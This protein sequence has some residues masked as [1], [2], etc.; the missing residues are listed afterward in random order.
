MYSAINNVVLFKYSL[1]KFFKKKFFFFVSKINGRKSGHGIIKRT[2]GGAKH[3]RKIMLI[4]Q[5]RNFSVMP[6]LLIEFL[7]ERLY[8]RKIGIVLYL[9]GLLNCIKIVSGVELQTYIYTNLYN[10][11]EVGSW[12]PL[13]ALPLGTIISNVEKVPLSGSCLLRSQN[14][15]GKLVKKARS[16][17]A[18]IKVLRHDKFLIVKLGCMALLGKNEI[19]DSNIF[20]KKTN[21]HAGFYRNLGYRPIVRGVAKN[22][23]DHPHGGKTVGGRFPVTPWG[24]L[25]KGYKTTIKKHRKQRAYFIRKLR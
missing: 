17:Y 25:T 16:G 1:C 4:D 3:K 5:K 12:L 19:N 6:G 2:R 20:S 14:M 22:P 24:I 21:K 15:A 23:V 11:S 9:N 7:Y 8:S 13:Y 18:V 10:Y